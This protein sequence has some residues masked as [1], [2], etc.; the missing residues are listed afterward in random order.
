MLPLHLHAFL[1]PL[2]G[3][4]HQ[5]LLGSGLAGTL[6]DIHA[7]PQ[8][9]PDP[10]GTLLLSAVAGI[11]PQLT[12]ARKPR[13]CPMQQRL[14]PFSKSITLALWTFALSTKPSVSTRMWRFLPFTFFPP[15]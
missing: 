14:D 12:E 2:P 8:T 15:S 4:P 3:S 5:H 1:G 10:V 9:L 7:P 13:L 6:D 11:H